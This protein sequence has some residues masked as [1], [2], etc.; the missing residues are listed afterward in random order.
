MDSMDSHATWPVPVTVNDR[1][2]DAAA[3]RQLRKA[4]SPAGGDEAGRPHASSG[5]EAGET[6]AAASESAG[7]HASA[8]TSTE[9]E[10]G[11]AASSDGAAADGPGGG[12]PAARKPPV[13][14]RLVASLLLVI[15]LVSALVIL[16]LIHISEPTRRLRGSRMP[17]SA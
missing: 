17:S 15:P 5:A 7:S 14:E 12:A 4:P 16:S 1:G 10:S 9:A 13:G 2:F 11:A 8:V 6:N 3:L